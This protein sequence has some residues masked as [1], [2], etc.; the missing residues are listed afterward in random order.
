[1]RTIRKLFAELRVIVRARRN[2]RDLLRFLVRRP[3]LLAAV[4]TY[5]TALLVSSRAPSRWKALAQVKTSALVG[6]PF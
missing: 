4:A 3:G 1:M 5:E 2:R 6:C